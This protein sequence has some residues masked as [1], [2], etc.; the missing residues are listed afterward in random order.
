VF[1]TLPVPLIVITAVDVQAVP[2]VLG[3]ELDTA[4]L[5]LPP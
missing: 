5:A 3:A 2:P 1:E 4:P